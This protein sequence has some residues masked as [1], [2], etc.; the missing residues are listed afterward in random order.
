MKHLA[1]APWFEV[2]GVPASKS[3]VRSSSAITRQGDPSSLL[4]MILKVEESEVFAQWGDATSSRRLQFDFFV[5]K[6][7]KPAWRGGK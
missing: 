2:P 3:N 1:P 6:L 5:E 7:V 4:E